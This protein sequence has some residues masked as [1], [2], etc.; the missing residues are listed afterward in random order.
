MRDIVKEILFKMPSIKVKLE[1]SQGEQ[2]IGKI[3]VQEKNATIKIETTSIFRGYVFPTQSLEL[4]QTAQELFETYLE[5]NI[6]SIAELYAGKLCAALNRQH[7]RDLFD[8]KVLLET[9]GISEEMRVAFI[10]YLAGDKRP[11]H[12]SPSPRIKQDQKSIFY[13]EFMGVTR[14]PINFDS[15]AGIIEKLTFQIKQQITTDEKEFLLSI[16]NGFPEWNKLNIPHLNELPALKWKVQNIQKMD[17]KKRNEQV[18]L[19]EACFDF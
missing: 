10:V 18:K 19:L 2:T 5:A 4:C 6:V 15:L 11:I 3:I 1:K 13:R 14:M 8:V 7:P 17:A 9:I 12:E 16:A